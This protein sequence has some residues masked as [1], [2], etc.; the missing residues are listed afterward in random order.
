MLPSETMIWQPEFT[1]KHFRETRAVQTEATSHPGWGMGIP[2]KRNRRG[3]VISP[4]LLYAVGNDAD[5][6]WW[7]IYLRFVQRIWAFAI[8]PTI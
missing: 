7:P 2:V 8:S 1:D 3:E 4:R 6:Y 5:E